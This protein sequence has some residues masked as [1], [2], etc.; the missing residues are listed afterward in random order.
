MD[1]ELAQEN[2]EWLIDIVGRSGRNGKLGEL[3]R[4]VAE[5]ELELKAQKAFIHK[6]LI[7]G[8]AAAM[9]G[10]AIGQ[11]LMKVLS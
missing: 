2:R 5:M 7:A 6:V 8:V 3:Q 1:C 10:S 9:G 4:K 11:L